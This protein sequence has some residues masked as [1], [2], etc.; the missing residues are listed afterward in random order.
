MEKIKELRDKTGAG[1]V[2]CSNALKEA[3]GD[4]ELAV[5]ILRKKGGAKAA[6]KA[7]RMTTE[8]VIAIAKSADN[9]KLV[10][11]K[12]QCETDFVGRNDDFKAFANSV[13]EAGVDGSAEEFFIAN[14]DAVVLK[15]GENLT[16]GG[17]ETLNGE[18]V[19]GYI[20]SNGKVASAV[21]FNKA[22][23]AMLAN[24]VAM[25]IVAMSPN[26]LNPEDVDPTDLAKEKEIYTEQLKNE[27]KKEEMIEKI[28]GGKISKY[29]EDVCL[30]KQ[31]FIKDDKK[32]IEDV[33]KES[34]ADL[35]IVKF[36][37][38]SL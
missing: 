6:K 12:V 17:A 27:G 3:N 2:E 16:L 23:D 4:I 21:V 32:K 15:V 8:G 18:F 7:D 22:C 13:A 19:N 25:H 38:F 20:H 14:K 11:A 33:L 37:R 24:D 26:C 34:D 30:T 31:F 28:L 29:Y 35:K 36:V 5:E 10:I 1:M 9:K